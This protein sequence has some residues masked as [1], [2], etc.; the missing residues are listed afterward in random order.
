MRKCHYCKKK[1]AVFLYREHDGYIGYI[2]PECLKVDDWDIWE[3]IR[4][5]EWYRALLWKIKH[6]Q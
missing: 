6:K 4:F 2:C 1:R 3:R 5:G